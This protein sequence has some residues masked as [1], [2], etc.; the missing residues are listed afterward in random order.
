MKKSTTIRFAALLLSLLLTGIWCRPSH[1]ISIK[2]EDKL[3]R[4]FMKYINLQYELITD[5]LVVQYVN[6]VGHKLLATMPPQPFDYHFY[7][8]K[9]DVYNAFAI[10]AGHIFINSGLL[11][12]MDSE[13]ELAGILGHEISH[14]VCRHLS[15]RIERSKKISLA[16]MAG[17]VAGIFLGATTGDATAM[18]T[19]TI[20]SM[21]A[22]QTASLAYSRDDE[23]QADQLGLVITTNAGYDPHGLLT[24]LKRIRTKQWFGAQQIPTYMQTHPATEERIVWIDAWITSHPDAIKKKKPFSREAFRRANIRLKALYGDPNNALQ[25]FQNALAKH[26][27]NE[28]LIYGYG[29]ALAQV[30]KREEAVRQLKRVQAK[31]A[32]DP[33][34]LTDLG[35]IYFLDGRYEE[36]LSA[37]EGTVSLGSDNP[38]G[39]FYQGR[40]Q[41]ELGQLKKAA[42]SFE[43]TI[44]VDHQYLPAYYF[45][46]ET[47]GRLNNMPDAHY[48]LGIYYYRKGQNRTARYHLSRAKRLLRDPAK[49]EEVDH[50]LKSMGPPSKEGQHDN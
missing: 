27:S 22:G 23:S 37:L 28:D 42:A 31:N 34:I 40:S 6:S 8:I 21:A 38:E 44:R 41:M 13:D 49:L 3:A 24:A 1:A 11:S 36:A 12:A 35:R 30:G 26:P 17:M 7:V 2:E 19:L 48:Y 50:A 39:L 46:G 47:N 25:E 5:P 16:T 45:L 14:V 4:E 32:L 9:E 20:G 18:Q 43:T 15:Q 29:L 33:Y 10:P